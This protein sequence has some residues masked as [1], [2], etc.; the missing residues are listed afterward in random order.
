MKSLRKITP[1]L[2][3]DGQG[4]EAAQFYAGIFPG[5]KVG[6]VSRYGEQDAARHGQ[7]P[8]SVLAV[9]FELDGQSFTA[10]NGGPQFPFTPAISFQVNCE[11]QDEIDHYWER[12][13]DGGDPEAQRCGWLKDRYGASW[14]VVPTIL[15]DMLCGSDQ[16]AAQRVMHALMEMG[17]LDIQQL[18]RAYA[19]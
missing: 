16:V 5:S 13:S 10:L 19:G 3:F 15:S 17:K 8:G 12:L 1:C 7:R 9:A 18:K 4:L 14:Q 11:T 2:W 6:A